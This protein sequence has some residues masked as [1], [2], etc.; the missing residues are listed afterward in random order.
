[1]VTHKIENRKTAC[2]LDIYKNEIE[3]SIEWQDVDCKKCLKKKKPD[4][5]ER[6]K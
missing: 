5:P 3:A 6:F 1:M 4:K 2:G